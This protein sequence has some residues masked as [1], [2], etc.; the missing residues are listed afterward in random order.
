MNDENKRQGGPWRPRKSLG[1]HFLRDRSVIQKIV[2]M[3][4]FS[5]S[6]Y[7]LE[8]GPGLGALTF[9]LSAS[10]GH[11]YAIEKDGGLAEKL[12]SELQR[13]AVANVTVVHQDILRWRVEDL[14]LPPGEKLGV[15]GNLPYNISTPFLERLLENRE[16]VGR[17][18][19]MFQIEVA[20]RMVASP[21]NKEYGSLTVLVQYHA[22][23][24]RLLEVSRKAF[25]PVPKVDSM[26]LGL[27]FERSHPLRAKDE[28][29]L[30]RVVRGAFSHRRKTLLNSLRGSLCA[31]STDELRYAFEACGIDGGKR[32]EALGIDDFICLSS[33]LPAKPHSA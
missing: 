10:V 26:V 5:P 14:P 31:F 13:R 25:Y 12:G 2:S 16:R 6:S 8:V 33:H 21:G 3:A 27:D 32:A 30:K 15:I 17:A 19:L 22:L 1:Q 4:G 20:R 28:D 18:V 9:P 29:H 11:L 24:Q 7:V 23:I